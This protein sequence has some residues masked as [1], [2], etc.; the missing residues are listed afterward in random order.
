MHFNLHKTMSIPHG[1]GGPGAG[2][3]AF[4]AHLEPF[5]PGPRVRKTD[6]GTF[7]F[8]RDRPKSI[9][10]VKAFHGNYGVLVRAYAYLREYGA[11]GLRK[12]T[13]AAVL[14]AN[15]IRAQLK[16]D[17]HVAF[18]SPSMHEVVFSD[19]KLKDTGVNTLDVAKRI[20]DYGYH[21]PTMYFPLIVPGALMIEPTESESLESLDGFIDSMKKIAEEIRTDPELVKTAPHNT[22]WRRLDE[23][24]AARKPIVRWKKHENL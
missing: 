3:I 17:F 6:E 23:A 18:D 20:M 11:E 9:G 4:G 12:V 10:R 16:D 14:N 22:G 15:Y 2:P 13:E 21:P 8:D 7:T 24:H 5:A 1:G 19:A